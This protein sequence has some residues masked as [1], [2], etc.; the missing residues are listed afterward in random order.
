MKILFLVA[1]FLGLLGCKAIP[2][3]SVSKETEIAVEPPIGEPSTPEPCIFPLK[4]TK[5]ALVEGV[6]WCD[7]SRGDCTTRVSYEPDSR[8]LTRT[9]SDQILMET[10]SE[11]EALG[12]WVTM[13]LLPQMTDDKICPNAGN[14]ADYDETLVLETP[15]VS[16][17]SITKLVTG[18]EYAA[19][20]GNR[21]SYMRDHLLKMEAKYFP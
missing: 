5:I 6:G 20:S 3:P 10:L 7:H 16:V 14:Y 11:E 8:V 17:E 18:C 2:I 4:Y 1:M 13:E 9:Q 12:F 15:A 19:G 21:V